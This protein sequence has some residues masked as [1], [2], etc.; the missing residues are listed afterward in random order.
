MAETNRL[1]VPENGI[2]S[3]VLDGQFDATQFPGFIPGAGPCNKYGVAA[4]FTRS[5]E[6][7]TFTR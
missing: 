6:I 3:L 2:T 4:R 7:S 1:V 5:S